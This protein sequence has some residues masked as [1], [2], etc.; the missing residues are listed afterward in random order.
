MNE[1][2]LPDR[3]D[4]HELDVNDGAEEEDAAEDDDHDLPERDVPRSTE[5]DDHLVRHPDSD[6]CSSEGSSE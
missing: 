1:A 3:H 4:G 5:R 6:D 2:I